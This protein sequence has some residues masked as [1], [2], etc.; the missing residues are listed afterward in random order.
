MTWNT[1]VKCKHRHTPGFLLFTIFIFGSLNVYTQPVLF[2]PDQAQTRIIS[3]EPDS[4]FA[5]PLAVGDF[6]GDGADD[7]AIGQSETYPVGI[8]AVYVIRGQTGLWDSATRVVDLALD[9]ADKVIVGP[10]PDINMPTSLAV[11]DLN[12]D[13][14]DDLAMTAPLMSPRS[15]TNAGRLYVALGTPSFFDAPTTLTLESPGAIGV[16][17]FDGAV[18]G[19]DLGSQSVF[20]GLDAHGVAFGDLNGD[21][22]DDLA[23]GAHLAAPKGRG[24]AG[25]VA[26]V[27]GSTAFSGGQVHDL[28]AAGL[29]I[30]GARQYYETGTHVTIADVTGDGIAELILACEAAGEDTF[31]LS[32]EGIV[33]LLRGRETWPT[34][35]DLLTTWDLKIRGIT[36]G[37]ALGSSVAVADLNR[38]GINDLCLGAT[39]RWYG[40]STADPLGAVE[41]HY[42]SATLGVPPSTIR[43]ASP[44]ILWYGAQPYCTM[45]WD[46]VAGRFHEPEF[47][48]LAASA[49]FADLPPDGYINGYIEI[50]NS[51]PVWAPN[52]VLATQLNPQHDY[53]IA[54]P[55]TGRFGFA[56]AAGDTNADG[57]DEVVIGAPFLGSGEVYVFQVNTIT[58]AGNSWM[59]Y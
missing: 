58:A 9:P 54:G 18:A 33:Y 50:L 27:F 10:T 41:V 16:V 2:L 31:Y 35:I 4:D 55:D 44:D 12:G 57:L 39:D 6:N 28:A 30:E 17:T 8:S 52:T 29:R 45:G 20:G 40:T 34:V 7:I 24:Q 1:R 23:V 43:P 49:V 48:S 19:G 38:D 59:W 14:L 5:R 21:G 37:V 13:G 46:A 22:I 26:V 47:D 15:R 56:L 53:R 42:G 11:G 32:T 3:P 25:Q 36:D 51:R